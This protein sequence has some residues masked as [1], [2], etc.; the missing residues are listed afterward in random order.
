MALYGRIASRGFATREGGREHAI[1]IRTDDGADFADSQKKVADAY[2][3]AL[4][5]LRLPPES[6]VFRRIFLSDVRNQ[7]PMLSASG[8][9]GS[10]ADAVAVSVIGQ[11]PLPGT[12]LAL[13]AYHLT[14]PDGLRKRR[15]GPHHLLV[16][17]NGARHLWSTGLCAGRETPPAAVEEQTEIIFAD[18]L[19]A[20]HGEAA[21]L[22]EHCVRTWLFLKGL[23][24]S[25]PGMLTSRRGVFDAHELT[26]ETHY[27]AATAIEGA[28]AHRFDVIAMDAYSQLDLRPGQLTYLND[29]TRLCPAHRYGATFE[30]G[31][32]VHYKDRTQHFIS[33]TASVDADGRVLHAGDVEAQAIRA[34]GNVE[35][36]LKSGSGTLGDLLYL[37]VYLRDAA[38][39]RIVEGVIAERLPDIPVV[40]V[41]AAVC[42][43]EWLVEMEGF[44]VASATGASAVELPRF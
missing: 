17:K 5:D 26:P 35:A 42:R 22:G 32:S 27:I 11:P 16:E 8:L 43:P 2:R 7:R 19:G 40:P 14:D 18:L 38:D 31:A 23:D 24:T 10:E 1:V 15:L 39:W 33:G 34:L 29:F 41:H 13:L 30:R 37:I 3:A 36:L 20:L 6:A 25:Y 4:R 44:G 9:L 28:G 21:S 12:R